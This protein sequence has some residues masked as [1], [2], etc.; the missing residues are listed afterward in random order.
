[1][2]DPLDLV[3]SLDVVGGLVLSLLYVLCLPGTGWLSPGHREGTALQ[4]LQWAT[5]HCLGRLGESGQ[6]GSTGESLSS[7][8]LW[9]PPIFHFIG[10]IH[11]NHRRQ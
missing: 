4:G 7:L 8:D 5:A 11:L 10:N 3:L 9:I 1:M 2:L 6:L